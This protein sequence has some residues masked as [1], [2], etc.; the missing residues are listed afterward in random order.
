MRNY[1]DLSQ[2]AP[3]QVALMIRDV[4]TPSGLA[5]DTATITMKK[6]TLGL[7]RM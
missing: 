7:Y 6:L 2:L 5:T 1:F 4:Q 3:G